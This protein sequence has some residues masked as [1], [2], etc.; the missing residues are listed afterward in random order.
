MAER[1]KSSAERANYHIMIRTAQKE[2]WMA[3]N[4]F[5]EIVEQ[6]LILLCHLSKRSLG[7]D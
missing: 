1:L 7:A 5:R 2:R 3:Q 6:I 4:G